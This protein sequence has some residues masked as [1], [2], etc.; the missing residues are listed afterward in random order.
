MSLWKR[1]FGTKRPAQ[2]S[3]G[4]FMEHPT[5]EFRDA[6]EAM[7]SA[8]ARLRRLDSWSEWITFTGQGQGAGS[9]GD[10]YH[11][12]EIR[13]RGEELALPDGLEVDLDA[14]RRT[15]GLDAAGAAV[16]VVGPGVL[17]VSDATPEQVAKVLDALYRGPLGDIPFEGE[18]DY[19]VG[20]EW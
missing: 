1:I 2:D 14:L 10:S 3:D 17:R 19:A 6:V 16:A 18:T 7:S 9:S 11:F 12:A 5:G 8:I 13:V 15:A 4:P 20:A